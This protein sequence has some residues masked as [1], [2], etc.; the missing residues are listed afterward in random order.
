MENKQNNYAENT[1]TP[2]TNHTPWFVRNAMSIAFN[3]C[4]EKCTNANGNFNIPNKPGP[5]KMVTFF[6]DI[7]AIF[8]NWHATRACVRAQLKTDMQYFQFVWTQNWELNGQAIVSH[9][10]CSFSLAINLWTKQQVFSWH[11]RTKCCYRLL[12][13]TANDWRLWISNCVHWDVCVFSHVGGNLRI[14]GDN[15]LKSDTWSGIFATHTRISSKAN[16]AF[17]MNART[18]S[19]DKLFRWWQSCMSYVRQ[20]EERRTIKKIRRMKKPTQHFT[21]H[22]MWNHT[23]WSAEKNKFISRCP[24]R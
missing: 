19:I 20:K 7:F 15:G 4:V 10:K 17:G 23:M 12:I 13:V 21:H 2:K 3:C 9:A 6:C 8:T 5:I 18:T 1:A 16:G 24:P 11:T 14:G 22:K